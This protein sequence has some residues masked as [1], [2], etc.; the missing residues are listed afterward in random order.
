MDTYLFSL[1]GISGSCDEQTDD[2]RAK[3]V[4][5]FS[6]RVFPVIAILHV[7]IIILTALVFICITVLVKE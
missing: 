6:R 1:H 5:L 7:L 2:I 3:F 4:A